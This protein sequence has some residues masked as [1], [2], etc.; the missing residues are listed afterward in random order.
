MLL[1]GIGPVNPP[2]VELKRKPII[3]YKEVN[4]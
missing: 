3:K 2:K 1:A 4:K